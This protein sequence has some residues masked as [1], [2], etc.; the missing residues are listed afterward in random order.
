MAN[1]VAISLGTSFTSRLGKAI[2]RFHLIP[3]TMAK[4]KNTM[5]AHAGKDMK[6]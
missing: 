4:I 5:A 2:L 1:Q 3:V 6:Q